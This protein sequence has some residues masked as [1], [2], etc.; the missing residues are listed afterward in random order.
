M[1]KY[2]VAVVGALWLVVFSAGS[3]WVKRVETKIEIVDQLQYRSNYLNGQIAA[4]PV[5]KTEGPPP[6]LKQ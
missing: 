5:A 6:V 1:N 2:L 3:W 4:A